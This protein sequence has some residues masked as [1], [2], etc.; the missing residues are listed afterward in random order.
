MSTFSLGDHTLTA[1]MNAWDVLAYGWISAHLKSHLSMCKPSPLYNPKFT[2]A[3][4]C[5]SDLSL[6]ECV[7]LLSSFIHNSFPSFWSLYW[8]AYLHISWIFTSVIMKIN[9]AI[10][11]GNDKINYTET[12][13]E[14]MW[15]ESYLSL[16][17]FNTLVSIQTKSTP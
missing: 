7:P 8:N 12:N 3:V 16:H 6:V 10:L 2:F 1:N 15:K 13:L 11:Q 9:N 4:Q 17:Y 5:Y 14:S